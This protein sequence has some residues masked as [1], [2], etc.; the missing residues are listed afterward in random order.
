MLNPFFCCPTCKAIFIS[1]TQVELR[2]HACYP[3]R[4]RVKS[5]LFLGH[6][7][8]HL[9]ASLYLNRAWFCWEEAVF[10]PWSSYPLPERYLP[11]WVSVS[12]IQENP[13]TG[14][15]KC[16]AEIRHQLSLWSYP[17]TKDISYE[18]RRKRA[19]NW[20]WGAGSSISDLW[21]LFFGF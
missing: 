20:G 6:L 10:T 5:K 4:S 18:G 15:G 1:Q 14:R 17:N 11:P 8:F 2:S 9:F 19:L 16:T 13:E 12:P 3:V 21:W 7:L